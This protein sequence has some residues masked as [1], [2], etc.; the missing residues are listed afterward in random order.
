MA[1]VIRFLKEPRPPARSKPLD[2]TAEQKLRHLKN[3]SPAKAKLV[4]R[5]IDSFIKD[6]APHRRDEPV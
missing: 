5:V 2:G 1:H 3:K 4:E 6:L